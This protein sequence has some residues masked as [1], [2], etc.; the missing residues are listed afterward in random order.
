MIYV[1]DTSSLRA[2]QHFFP[3]VFPSIWTD[4]NALV[5]AQQLISTREVWRELN[6]QAVSADVLN[7]AKQ[8]KMLFKTPTNDELHFVAEIFK[9]KHFQG[10]IDAQ[11]RLKGNPVADPFVIVCARVCNGTVVTEEGWNPTTNPITPK[12]NAAKIPNVCTHFKIP[13]VNLETFMHRQ[14]WTF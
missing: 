2:L 1:F 12:P 5:N 4:I 10:L 3:S 14:N 13:C 11:A 6:N 9:V 7:W 8:N